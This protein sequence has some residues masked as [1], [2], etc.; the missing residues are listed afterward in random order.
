[1]NVPRP[2]V[3]LLCAVL[4]VLVILGLALAGSDAGRPAAGHAGPASVSSSFGVP[5]AVIRP[6]TR[7]VLVCPSARAQSGVTT[8][9]ITAA[10]P[11]AGSGTLTIS[12]FGPH[13][14]APVAAAAPG[15]LGARYAVKPA[16]SGAFLVI[17][18]GSRA[19]GLTANVVTRT[20]S[21]AARGIS[22]VPCTAPAGQAWLVGGGAAPGRTSLIFL[23]NVDPTPA[24]VN[25][26]VYTAKGAQQPTP[27]QGVQV[28]PLGQ[29]TVPVDT[30]VPGAGPV[31]VDVSTSSGRVSAAEL[32]LQ[33]TGLTIQGV[34]WVA[35]SPGSST[36]TVITGIPGPP[37]RGLPGNAAASR[38]LDLVVPGSVSANVSLRLVT[39]GG[40]LSPP[41]LTNQLVPA[42][43]L[44]V[45]DLRPYASAAPY[46]VQ[47]VS[48][49]PVVASVRTVLGPAGQ[50]QDF[51]YAAG[52]APIEG[53]VVLP[54]AYN[55]PGYG[56]ALQFAN[57][58]QTDVVVTIGFTPTVAGL[59]STQQLTV[60][61]GQLVQHA[62]G[63]GDQFI[64][65]I[66]VTASRGGAALTVG[67]VFV[68][69]GARGPLV[70]GGPVP[71]TPLTLTFPPV[72]TDPAV[73]YPGH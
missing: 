39:S 65:S 62:V 46:S 28:P 59:R 15:V 12:R 45:V 2:S 69:A 27:G 8:S 56:T 22:S 47:V 42:G 60:P 68:E 20:S 34:D 23:T 16:T 1:M 66:L 54:Y 38:T 21:G 44:H 7:A 40:T 55:L 6:V 18:T 19:R 33:Q 24:V 3:V 63:T 4:A 58:G 37:A 73:G 5:R 35:P 29:V 53:S 43:Q 9:T 50:T 52:S 25:L 57:T 17:A 72:I 67:W 61:A 26:T 64:R 13:P 71:Q 49:Q 41:A 14:G 10:A 48:D 11:D 30:L 36:Q 51:A 32:D 70:T 31:A